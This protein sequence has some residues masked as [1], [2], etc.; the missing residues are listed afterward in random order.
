MSWNVIDVSRYQGDINFTQVK[1][2][3]K[4]SGVIIRAGIGRYSDGTVQQ[5]SKFLKNIKGFTDVELPIGLYYFSQAS[6]ETEAINEAKSVISWAKGYK[7]QLPIAFDIEDEGKIQSLS[8]S[9]ITKNAIAFCTIIKNAGYQTCVYSFKNFLSNRINESVIRQ[10]GFDIW[11]AHY[12]TYAHPEYASQYVIWQYSST[13]TVPGISG[14]VD[15]NICY[16]DYF[17][18]GKNMAQFVPRKSAP[19]R[20]DKNWITTAYG[21]YNHAMKITATGEV[22]PNCTGLRTTL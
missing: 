14:N 12:T 9:Q 22:I 17:S 5:D 16:K 18:G 13:G 6:T 15:I 4:C 1:N 20:T 7:I 19:S 2:S 11:L 3:S 21:G 10:A 8:A